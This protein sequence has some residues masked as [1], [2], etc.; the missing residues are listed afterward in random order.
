MARVLIVD[1]DPDVRQLV[2]MKLK[3]DGIQTYGATNG[4]EA[5]DVLSREDIDLVVLDLMMPV[6]DGYETCRRIRAGQP[7]AS[8]PVIMLTARAQAADMQEGFLQGANDYVVKPF[9]PRELLS[10]VRST[11]VRNGVR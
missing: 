4:A 3:L 9:S 7:T 1:D 10:R 2:E 6:M 5:L 11:L 8:I